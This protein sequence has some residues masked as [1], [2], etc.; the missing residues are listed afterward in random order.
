MH[1]KDVIT[2]RKY[3]ALAG[4]I[5]LK[6]E[7]GASFEDENYAFDYSG[8]YKMITELPLLVE[9]FIDDI[10]KVVTTCSYNIVV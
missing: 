4:F 7:D 8:N 1:D 9:E 5:T 2:K 6:I 3:N 10:S